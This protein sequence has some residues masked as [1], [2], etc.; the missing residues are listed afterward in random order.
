MNLGGRLLYGILDLG[1]VTPE[2][3]PRVLEAMLAG[4]VGIVQ[5]RAKG[6]PLDEIAALARRLQPL[7]RA[8]GVPFVLN[9]HVPLAAELGLDGA[10]V[11]QD[12]LSVAEA[13]RLLG[14]GRIVGKSTHSLAQAEAAAAEAPDYLGFGP[15]FATPTK[16]DYRPIG[17]DDIRRAH[18]RVALPIYCIGGIKR[19]NTPAVLAAGARRVVIVSGILQAPGIAAYCREVNALLANAGK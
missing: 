15:L 19:E 16:P 14:P 18:E 13:R 12:D 3:A 11:G 2:A 6:R 1:Y 10:H 7:A 4:G 8:A 17:T 9:D 5:L